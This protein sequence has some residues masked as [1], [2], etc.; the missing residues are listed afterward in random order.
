M[1]EAREKAQRGNRREAREKAQKE[2]AE[3]GF[4]V[5]TEGKRRERHRKKIKGLGWGWGNRGRD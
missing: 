3:K 5:A 1:T 4:G 2:G